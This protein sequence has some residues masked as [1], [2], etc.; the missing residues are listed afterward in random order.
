[1]SVMSVEVAHALLFEKLAWRHEEPLSSKAANSSGIC[2][3]A[4]W[5]NH[6]VFILLPSHLIHVSSDSSVVSALAARL[7]ASP[8]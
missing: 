6:E 8:R 5:P 4:L 2:H 7:P 1:M 3:I